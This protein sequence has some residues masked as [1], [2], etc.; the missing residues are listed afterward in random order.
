MK[1]I[2]NKP[3]FKPIEV[4]FVF[5]TELEI[6]ALASMLNVTTLVDVLNKCSGHPR[7]AQLIR[8]ALIASGA[9]PLANWGSFV[10][11]IK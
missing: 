11:L 9:N 5:E 2:Q 6:S 1:L 4:T 8:E 7:M 3:A 10:D